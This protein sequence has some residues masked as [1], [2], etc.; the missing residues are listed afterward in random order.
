[1]NCFPMSN[2]HLSV[3]CQ[4]ISAPCRR[5]HVDLLLCN[6]TIITDG[7]FCT[8]NKAQSILPLRV[9]YAPLFTSIFFTLMGVKKRI[10]NY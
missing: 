10:T 9:T 1:M 4:A 2:S 8:E 6:W 3:V 7:I 5:V